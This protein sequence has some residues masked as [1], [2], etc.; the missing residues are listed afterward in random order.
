MFLFCIF[1]LLFSPKLKE[2][3][4]VHATGLL[5]GWNHVY[6]PTVFYGGLVFFSSDT[7]RSVYT[8]LFGS[9]PWYLTYRKSCTHSFG[10][11]PFILSLLFASDLSVSLLGSLSATPLIFIM[12]LFNSLVLVCLQVSHPMDRWGRCRCKWIS[13]L[14]LALEST[15]SAW[16][17]RFSYT[18]TCFFCHFYLH[19]FTLENI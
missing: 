14:T 9:L 17:V 8:P 18:Q 2:T 6:S 3:L 11:C 7:L 15:K 1:F 16:R 13:S 12:P 10:F 5:W 19:V 4:A